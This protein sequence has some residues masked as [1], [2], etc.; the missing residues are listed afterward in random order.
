[1]H[2]GA[3]GAGHYA[4]M[5]HNGIEYGLMQ[6][7]A[8]G[9][10]LLA[11][12]DIVTDVHGCLPGLDPRHRRPLLA[13]RPAGQGAGGGPGP[14]GD[15]RLRPGL[16]RGPLDRGGG[17]RQ[18]GAD[19]GHLGGAVRPVRLPPGRLAGDEGRRRR[20]ATS[21]AATRS[22]GARGGRGRSHLGHR[23]HQLTRHRRTPRTALRSPARPGRHARA[24]SAPVADRTSAAT[25]ARSC[26]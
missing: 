7:Y 4:K 8:E 24:P 12:K 5:V 6:A 21:S 2:A 3:V 16:R 14:A 20:C 23:R 1:M 25:S 11:A 26:R 10:E 17:H 22:E 9:Y 15:Q 13:A 18:R 19:A